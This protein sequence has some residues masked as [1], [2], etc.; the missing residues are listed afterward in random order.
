MLAVAQREQA[1]WTTDGTVQGADGWVCYASDIRLPVRTIRCDSHDEMIAVSDE[2]AA[3]PFERGDLLWQL[4]IIEHPDA[5]GRPVRTAC[6]MFDHMVTDGRSMHLLEQEL[7]HGAPPHGDRYRGNYRTWVSWAREAYRHRHGGPS[8]PSRDFWL[9]VLDGAEADTASA[10]P[11]AIRPA[12]PFR[13][14]ATSI[15]ATAPV[16]FQQLMRASRL[17]RTTPFLMVVASAVAVAARA[18]RVDDLVFRV[19]TTGRP[20]PFM[21]T[22]GWFAD[23]LPM[24][25]RD[26]ALDDTGRV[27]GL[28]APLWSGMMAHQDTPWDFIRTACSP[29]R[30]PVWEEPGTQQLVV[31]FWPFESR[32]TG[33]PGT[34]V[35]SFPAHI[36][37]L[38]LFICPRSNGQSEVSCM[39]NADHFRIEETRKFVEGVVDQLVA[40]VTSASVGIPGGSVDTRITEP[41]TCGET[42]SCTS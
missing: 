15:Q 13:G 31:N 35:T 5:A 19:I 42:G 22:H 33:R 40:L 12:Q 32:S 34:T 4:V 39:F 21:N 20:T 24:R 7:L 11:F 30:T 41:R 6:A 38:H 36:E 14:V 29:S 10:I 18:G 2:L 8:S 23:S 17:L 9:R 1:L 16:S 28:L 27:L 37:S 25:L 26:G 3:K